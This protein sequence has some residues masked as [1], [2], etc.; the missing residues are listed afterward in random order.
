M[1]LFGYPVLVYDNVLGNEE[2]NRIH[3]E[4]MEKQNADPKPKSAWECDVYTTCWDS[5][6]HK[7]PKYKN[8]FGVFLDRAEH[9][10][11]VH[12]V[13]EDPVLEMA[14]FNSYKKEQFQEQHIHNGT[15]VSAVYFLNAPEGSAPLK[16][17]NPTPANF[18]I[19]YQF[20][21]ELL[22]DERYVKAVNDRLVVFLSH[23]PHS[24]PRGFNEELR[25]SIAINYGVTNRNNYKATQL[26][27]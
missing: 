15:H 22:E 23:T 25:Y 26:T 9:F 7:D 2:R 17:H 1:I 3:K 10:L 4:C 19:A 27:S 21:N 8:A 12:G 18:P 13:N 11:E 5:D 6:M 24:V 16:F 14:W 20:T